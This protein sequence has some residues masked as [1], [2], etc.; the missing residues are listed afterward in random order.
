LGS[1]L[2]TGFTSHVTPPKTELRPITAGLL[3]AGLYALVPM[4]QM[5]CMPSSRELIL[6]SWWGVIYFGLVVTLTRSTSLAVVE[7]V[8]VLVL[9]NI[10]E[11]FAESVRENI[12]KNFIRRQIFMK[13]LGAA[14]VAM[15]ISCLLLRGSH[16]VQLC[17]WGVG[18][19]ILYFTAS[20]ATLTAPFYR[21]FSQSLKK[22]SDVLFLIDPAASPAVSACTAL[23]KRILSYWFVVFVLVMSLTAVPYIMALPLVSRFVGISSV[24]VAPFIAAVVFVAGF[25]SFGLGGLVYLRFESDLRIA[26]DQVRLATLSTVQARFSE[27]FSNQGALSAKEW[28]QLGRLKDTADYLSKS[29]HLRGSLQSLGVVVAAILP[30]LVSMV[31]SVLTYVK[32]PR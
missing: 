29:G 12:T 22:H 8:E 21:C 26:V 30:P 6:L 19:F 32:K 23:A 7:I 31:G 25:F 16:W 15:L 28:V 1:F 24:H 10:S 17:I 9:P 3:A 14:S 20:Q 18:F 11:E 13:S 2:G 4:L 27:L 5:L